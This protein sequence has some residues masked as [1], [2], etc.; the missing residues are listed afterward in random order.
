VAEVTVVVVAVVVV[1]V[2][3]MAVVVM[4]AAA[5]VRHGRG[6]QREPGSGRRNQQATTL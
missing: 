1:A 4:M 3:V 6:A 2:V 5:R